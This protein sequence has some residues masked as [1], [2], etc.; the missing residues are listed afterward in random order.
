MGRKMNTTLI[1]CHKIF[2]ATGTW[3]D[4]KSTMIPFR[5]QFSGTELSLDGWSVEGMAQPDIT[6][7]TEADSTAAEVAWAAHV[8][9]IKSDTR[10]TAENTFLKFCDSINGDTK[11]TPLTPTQAYAK[12]KAACDAGQ[13]AAANLKI[14]PYL[15][16][17]INILAADIGNVSY[18]SDI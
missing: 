1:V 17:C 2:V 15:L 12:W 14:V 6:Q 16:A 4:W 8:Q 5:V 11:H 3:Y 10:K 18:H 9:S 13:S 7:F